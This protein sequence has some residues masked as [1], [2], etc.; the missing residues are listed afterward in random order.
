MNK[1]TEHPAFLRRE[2]ASKVKLVSVAES[3]KKTKKCRYL[4]IACIFTAVFKQLIFHGL[5][6]MEVKYSLLQISGE[7]SSCRSDN[8]TLLL[9]LE[10]WRQ[11]GEVENYRTQN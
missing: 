4:C 9:G 11:L 7:V 5:N 8:K 1:D 3:I 2:I 10:V 6:V